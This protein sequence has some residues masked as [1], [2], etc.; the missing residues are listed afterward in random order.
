VVTADGQ[1][2][3]ADATSHPDLFWALRGGGGSFGV[4]TAIEMRLFP[5]TDVYAGQLWWP[6]DAASPV[7]AA[8]RELAHADLPEEF[9][10]AARL[11]HFPPIPDLPEHLR[12]RSFVVVFVCHQG[13]PGDA[14]ALLAPLRALGPATDTIG[15]M[16]VK[17]LGHLHLDPEQPVRSIGD[18]LMLASL[19]DDAIKAFAEVVGPEADGMLLWAEILRLG[20][21]LKRAR[22]GSGALAAIDADYQLSAGGRAPA[23]EAEPAVERRVIAVGTALRPWAAGQMYLN[24]ADTSRDPSCFWTP[25]AYDRLR[26]IKAAVDPGDIIR[27]NHPV[28]PQPEGPP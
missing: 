19:P 24:L 11:V 14:D 16:P 1:L 6:I 5:L 12:G 22:P 7:L 25:A 17:D 21:E 4:V 9:T 8:W 15:T 20:G 23:P 28:P 13:R 3:R 2:I 18:G 10:T 26:R 27:A